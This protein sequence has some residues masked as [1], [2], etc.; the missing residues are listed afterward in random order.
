MRVADARAK[1]GLA[2]ARRFVGIAADGRA[3]R[4]LPV[5]VF[6][7]ISF[8]VVFAVTVG[9]RRNGALVVLLPP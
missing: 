3:P 1:P 8:A 7:V 2:S 5:A 6:R 4:V 9:G